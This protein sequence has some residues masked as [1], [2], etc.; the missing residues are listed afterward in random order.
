MTLACMEGAVLRLQ[1]SQLCPSIS[2]EFS[3]VNLKLLHSILWLQS[4]GMR[5]REEK[6]GEFQSR[7]VQDLL[8]QEMPRSSNKQNRPS[9]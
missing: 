6:C 3:A 7:E 4:L 5:G 9:E 2:S 1:A 8:T